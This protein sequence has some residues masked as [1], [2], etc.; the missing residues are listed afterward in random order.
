MSPVYINPTM[1]VFDVHSK[2]TIKI[3]NSIQNSKKE[4][5]LLINAKIFFKKMLNK[6]KKCIRVYTYTYLLFSSFFIV[7]LKCTL[8]PSKQF[9][10]LWPLIIYSCYDIQS[11]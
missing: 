9:S 3:K 4:K 10:L 1:A 5:K 7:P 8:D 11:P 6:L 2:N